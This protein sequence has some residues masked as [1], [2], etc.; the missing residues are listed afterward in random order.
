MSKREVWENRIVN[1][2]A[3]IQDGKITNNYFDA[4]VG[5]LFLSNG[6]KQKKKKN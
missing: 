1:M 6:L 5:K 2:I 4:E 3:N